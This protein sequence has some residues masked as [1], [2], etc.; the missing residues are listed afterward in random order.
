MRLRTNTLILLSLIALVALLTTGIHGALQGNPLGAD[1]YTFWKAARAE[2]I[3]GRSAYDPSVAREIQVDIQ[4][5]LSTPGE[6][7]FAFSYPVFALLLVAPFSLLPFDWAQAAWMAVNFVLL[8]TA[9]LALSSRRRWVGATSWAFYPVCFAL[10]LGNLDLILAVI[11]LFFF[12]QVLLR[13]KG[14]YGNTV[15]MGMLI[16]VTTLKPQFSWFFLILAAL[17]A[18]RQ[19]STRFMLGFLAGNVVLWSLGFLWHPHWLSEWVAQ[20]IQY[21]NVLSGHSSPLQ[22]WLAMLPSPYDQAARL[23]T[24]VIII[25]LSFLFIRSAW[26]KHSFPIRLLGWCGIVTYFVHPTG[27]SYEQMTFLIPVFLWA[28]D[29]R[30]SGKVLA[31][32]LGMLVLSWVALIA[33]LTGFDRLADS[34]WLLFAAAAWLAWITVDRNRAQAGTI[35]SAPQS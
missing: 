4:G 27:F 2:F 9:S 15:W 35:Q 16:A 30:S 6:D 10:I 7:Q 17:I 34:S 18:L 11:W 5:R 13:Y 26:R 25:A 1:F 12:S 3:E 28:V 8:L 21:L 31:A 29:E 22:T 24:W 32:W 19:K 20:A 14:R 23:I 33:T